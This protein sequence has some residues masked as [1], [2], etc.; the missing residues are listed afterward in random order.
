MCADSSFNHLVRTAEPA[1][2]IVSPRAFAVFRLIT[3]S[4]LLSPIRR[5]GTSVRIAGGSLADPSGY[6]PGDRA[7]ACRRRWLRILCGPTESNARKAGALNGN[8]GRN[9]SRKPPHAR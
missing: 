5:I 2:E 4:N 9:I 1:G 8:T 6:S 7:D 3:S